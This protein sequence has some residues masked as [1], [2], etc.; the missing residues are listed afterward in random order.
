MV[1]VV[2]TL[3]PIFAL[4]VLGWFLRTREFLPRELLNSLNR[5]VFYLAIPAMIFREVATASFEAN[6]QL[7]LLLATLAP[8]AAVFLLSLTAG[9]IL[10]L[11]ASEKGTF[12]QS[13]FHGNL[14]YI[15]LAVCY[16]L[17]GSEGFARAGILAGFLI[18]WQNFL[19]VFGLQLWSGAPGR[20]IRTG[21][22]IQKVFSNPAIFSAL[23]GIVFS[24]LDIGLPVILDRSLQI[25][26]SMALP[27]AL[28]VIGGSISFE[29]IRANM[30]WALCTALLKLLVVPALGF[31]AY[32][33]LGLLPSQFLPGLILLAT[34]TA[35]I[36]YVMSSEMNGSTEL[37]SATVSVNTVLSGFTYLFWLHISTS[38][39]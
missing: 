8:I 19:S 2:N 35:T 34:P 33:G 21:Y 4:I 3:S 31:M 6:F 5:L 39:L 38:H 30:T 32:R 20:S 11:S 24:L 16:Y 13:S 22:I 17:L 25:L 7:S 28:L 23:G 27:L 18:V 10:P 12:M 14:G 29:L 15:G 26:S 37:A 36:T 1:H 9:L